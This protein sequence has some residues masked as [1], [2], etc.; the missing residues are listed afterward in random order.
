MVKNIVKNIITALVIGGM[1]VFVAGCSQ[2]PGNTSVSD[3]YEE[4]T[5]NAVVDSN[6]DD[7]LTNWII[8]QSSINAAVIASTMAVE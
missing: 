5:N 2:Y 3:S 6:D 8:W 7:D 1:V 4:Q